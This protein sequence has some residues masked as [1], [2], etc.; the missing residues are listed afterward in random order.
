MIVLTILHF[1]ITEVVPEDLIAHGN[2][3][4]YLLAVEDTKADKD[5][6]LL[7]CHKFRTDTVSIFVPYPLVSFPCFL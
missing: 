2:S 5:G 4:K 1:S 7:W 6:K 3:A